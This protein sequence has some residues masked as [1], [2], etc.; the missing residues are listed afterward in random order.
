MRTTRIILTLL[1][2]LLVALM[3]KQN[4][5]Y[6]CAT[7]GK[8]AY[9]KFRS[10]PAGYFLVLMDIS[11]YVSFPRRGEETIYSKCTANISTSG[12]PVMDGYTATSKIRDFET[13]QRL[14]P[15]RIIALTGVTNHEAK[16]QAFDAGVDEYYAK[17]VRMKE[18]KELVDRVQTQQ[19]EQPASTRR[20]SWRHGLP[21]RP[22]SEP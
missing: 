5:I 12:R 1:P 6:L 17:P 21:H 3:I 18:L 7:T 15:T 2:K 14:P 4:L 11:M 9:E 8:E 22:G 13:K 20:Q 10:R 16:R 19:E